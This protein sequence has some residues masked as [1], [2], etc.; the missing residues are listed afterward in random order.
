LKYESRDAW[1]RDVVD[2]ILHKRRNQMTVPQARRIAEGEVKVYLRVT[3]QYNF[4]LRRQP[5]Q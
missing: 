5:K 3:V 1:K 2:E 4:G